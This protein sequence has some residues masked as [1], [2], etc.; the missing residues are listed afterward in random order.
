MNATTN[1]LRHQ[2]N[3]LLFSVCF[4]NI[5]GVSQKITLEEKKV[6]SWKKTFDSFA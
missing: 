5:W 4:R 6:D 3:Q 1:K 2:K